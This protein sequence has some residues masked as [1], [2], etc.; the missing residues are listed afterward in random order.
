MLSRDVELGTLR[1]F[2]ANEP[3]V[4]MHK[5]V[6]VKKQKLGLAQLLLQ[7]KPDPLQQLPQ[8]E[9]QQVGSLFWP[10]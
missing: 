5:I 8:V 10:L 7:Q 3:M 9:L 2:P 6:M 4:W 1:E